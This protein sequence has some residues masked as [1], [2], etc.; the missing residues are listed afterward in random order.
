MHGVAISVLDGAATFDE[1]FDFYEARIHL[2][3]RFRQRLAFVPFNLAHPKWT[4]DP[5]FELANHVKSHPVAPGTTLDQAIQIALE[6]GEP[7]LD[8]SRP[9]WLIYV[10]ENVEGQT[11]LAMMSHH[12]FVDGATLVAMST[13]LT[14]MAADAEP[15]APAEHEWQPE[16]V[17]SAIQLSQEA[18]REQAQSV[19]ESFRRGMPSADLTRKAGELMTRM[20]QP[21]MQTPWNA[22]L[23]GPK[24]QLATLQYTLDDF[25]AIRK[26]LGG[27]VNDVA[28][29]VVTEGAA[30]YLA[31][32]G[33]QT[34]NQYL[35]LMCPVNVRSED[36]DPLDMA[37]NQVSGMFPF[38][39]ASPKS[40][41]DRYLEVRAEMRGIKDR[42]DAETLHALQQLQPPVPPVAM[43]ATLGVGTP[44]DPTLV[45]ARIPQPVLSNI[46]FRPQQTGFNF[47][48]TNVLGPN[49]T[50]YVA[51]HKV[52]DVF[53]T[54]MLGGNLGLGVGVGSYDGKMTFGF[55]SDPRLLPDTDRFRDFVAEAFE[56]LSE[57]G[58]SL[59][60][61]NSPANTIAA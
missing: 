50:Q 18:I 13:V 11:L 51:G 7:L 24:R 3:P 31:Y 54:L 52:T 60:L 20:S 56:E 57:L 40:M 44:L 10:L 49:W 23:I 27:T 48:C 41:D 14:D 29:S 12:A 58:K 45:A 32:K 26:T 15:P 25:K 4:D 61:V 16:P 36:D 5:D 9:L 8:R 30:R 55:T 35:R 17:P 28:V 37:G 6:L 42:G 21:V 43:A 47:T 2:I 38:L 39:S 46:G 1:I 59:R 33:E 19:F 22:G 53:G 34:E